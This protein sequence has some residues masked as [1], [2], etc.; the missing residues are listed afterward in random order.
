MVASRSTKRVEVD[1]EADKVCHIRDRRIT[2]CVV[3]IFVDLNE[4]SLRNECYN[5]LLVSMQI[6]RSNSLKNSNGTKIFSPPID[7][8]CLC[9]AMI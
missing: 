1:M 9:N 8:L 4:V 7:R 3:A 2:G 6:F 5:L